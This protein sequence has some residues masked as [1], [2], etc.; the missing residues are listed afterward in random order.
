MGGKL[1]GGDHTTLQ[2]GSEEKGP[3]QPP[4]RGCV[5]V[6]GSLASSLKLPGRIALIHQPPFPL[7]ILLLLLQGASRRELR[8]ACHFLFHPVSGPGVSVGLMGPGWY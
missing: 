5:C 8:I 7:G 3:S 1:G 4:G 6:R 2:L